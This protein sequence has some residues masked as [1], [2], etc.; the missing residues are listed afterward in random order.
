MAKNANGSGRKGS[1][2]ANP[3]RVARPAGMASMSLADH[4]RS[5]GHKPL[6]PMAGQMDMMTPAAR[7]AMGMSGK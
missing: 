1:R 5:S 7:R 4:A 3:A 2:A 6:D